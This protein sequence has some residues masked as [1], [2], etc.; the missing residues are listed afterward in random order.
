MELQKAITCTSA[1]GF[2]AASALAVSLAFTSGGAQETPAPHTASA[3]PTVAPSASTPASPTLRADEELYANSVRGAYPILAGVP[4]VTIRDRGRMLCSHLLDIPY[5]KGSSKEAGWTNLGMI[6]TAT[7]S[8]MGLEGTSDWFAA[9]DLT[10][11]Y[12]CPEI[13]S[14]G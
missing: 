5:V 1:V 13:A 14:V 7:R 11:K 12:L 9:F 3:A 6:G 4:A 10:A 2:V 8:D